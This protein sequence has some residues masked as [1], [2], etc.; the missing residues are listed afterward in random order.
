MSQ[1]FN[2]RHHFRLD[3]A[4]QNAL[5]QI[6]RH[7]MLSKSTLMRRYVQ[8]GVQRDALKYAEDAE[9]LISV[10]NALRRL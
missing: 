8:E 4:T 9:R 10:T 2:K 6:C 3:D 5:E 7:T 1:N